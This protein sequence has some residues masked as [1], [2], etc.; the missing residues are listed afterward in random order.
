MPP[1]L[2]RLEVIMGRI[3]DQPREQT[4]ADVREFAEEEPANPGPH[5]AMAMVSSFTWHDFTEAE[6]HLARASLL[7]R[8]AD[9]E[10][11]EIQF[12]Q[13]LH[14]AIRAEFELIGMAGLSDLSLSAD[15]V[16][17][18]VESGIDV[19]RR[20][21]QAMKALTAS[22][23]RLDES[24][25][26]WT[27]HAALGA[28]SRAIPAKGDEFRRNVAS[29]AELRNQDRTEALAGLFH[30]YAF[31]HIRDHEGSIRSGE[32]LERRHPNSP[33]VKQAM[34]SCYFYKHDYRN[35]ERYYRQ[36]FELAPESPW[37]MLGLARVLTL[38][39]GTHNLQEAGELA[40]R[41]QDAD[42]GGVLDHTMPYFNRDFEIMEYVTEL[43]GF[44]E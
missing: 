11:P 23:D 29:L 13:A 3:V 19:R 22:V 27:I 9:P 35:A 36:A 18:M 30:M 43:G 6:R 5:V 16:K 44:P 1:T 25:L 42:P 37:V 14:D 12:A 2:D 21:R 40:R 17:R 28:F 31:R 39:G 24:A 8:D 34:G 20:S 38:A 33:L 7:L 41:A 10:D 32:V 15:E 26:A 4:L